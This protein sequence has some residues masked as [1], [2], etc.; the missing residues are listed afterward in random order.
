VPDPNRLSVVVRLV[1]GST[2][3]LFAADAEQ[4]EEES[5]IAA[6][7]TGLESAV[8]KVGHHGSASATTA[9][10]LDAV[11]PAHAI[12]SVGRR[13]RFGH[14]ADAVLRRLRERGIAVA[15]TDEDGAVVM[16][17]DGRTVSRVHWR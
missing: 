1:Y 10:W 3:F 6:Y 14:P 4:E 15:R 8:L 2:A 12:I 11:R 16:A 7:G 5:L 13:N 17:S 9:A